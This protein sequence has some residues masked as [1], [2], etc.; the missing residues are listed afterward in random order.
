MKVV[1]LKGGFGARTPNTNNHFKVDYATCLL[2][3]TLNCPYLSKKETLTAMIKCGIN[4]GYL[5]K[6]LKLH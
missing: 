3:L 4:Y 5:K 1:E 6:D 2:K